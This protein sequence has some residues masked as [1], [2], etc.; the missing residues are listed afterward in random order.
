[1]MKNFQKF[2]LKWKIVKHFMRLK[3]RAA[4]RKLFSLL[5]THS[6]QDK[7]ILRLWNKNFSNRYIQKYRDICFQSGSIMEFLGVQNWCSA[8]VFSNTKQKHVC[9]EICKVRKVFGCVVE[10]YYFQYQVS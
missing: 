8:N 6:P 9:W 1:M 3:Q 2:P 10:A 7:I 4:L 5:Q